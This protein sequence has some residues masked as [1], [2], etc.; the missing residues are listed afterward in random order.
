MIRAVC[1]LLTQVTYVSTASVWVTAGQ[2]E[3]HPVADIHEALEKTRF[4][5]NAKIT[6][7]EGVHHVH[8]TITMGKD[9]QRVTIEGEGEGAVLNGG[10]TVPSHQFTPSNLGGNIVQANLQNTIRLGEVTYSNSLSSCSNSKSELYLNGNRMTVARYP[11]INQTTGYW[12]WM[13]VSSTDSSEPNSFYYSQTDEEH[14]LKSK[15]DTSASLHGYWGN[16]WGDNY[17]KMSGVD[18]THRRITVNSST[19]FVYPVKANARFMIVD[20]L[21]QLDSQGEYFIDRVSRVLYFYPPRPLL[22]GDEIVLSNLTTVLKI[23]NGV[24]HVLDN[25]SVKYSSGTNLVM[26]NVNGTSASN[27]DFSCAA[28]QAVSLSGYSNIIENSVFTQT[29]CHGVTI[30]GG[31]VVSLTRGDNVFSGN[32]VSN[33]SNWKRTYVPGI[34]WA[35]VGNMFKNNIV[36]YGPHSGILGKG[37]DNI[38]ENNLLQNLAYE[39]LDTG[40]WYSGRS[41]IARNNTILNNTFV[42]VRT[43]VPVHLGFPSVQGVYNDDQLSDNN[44][45]NNTFIRC[46]CGTFIG[47]GRRHTVT[48]NTYINVSSPMHIDNRGQTWEASYCTAPNGTFWEEM[49]AVNYTLPPYSTAYPELLDVDS[50]CVP[51]HNVVSFNRYCGAGA[52]G[53]ADFS[54]AQAKAWGVTMEGNI[55][56]GGC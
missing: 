55:E 49:Y 7:S 26:D 50:P 43:A 44:M 14:I 46:Q 38:F 24:N 6:L 41:W 30:N 34:S 51:V 45:I 3:K 37:N 52:S 29:G 12:E 27:G 15:N 16:D 2:H 25:V 4:M 39:T 48:G 22:P 53:F 18:A 32:L 42:D 20:S 19:P 5:P 28:D 17:V 31:D 13:L 35:G 36:R 47:G 8:E 54:D 23:S 11:N 1:A 33:F 40:A 10:V 56:F 9:H 21:E